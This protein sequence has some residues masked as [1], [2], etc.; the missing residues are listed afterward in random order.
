MTT[1]SPAAAP[2]EDLTAAYARAKADDPGAR[3]RDIADKLGVTEGRLVDARAGDGVERLAL[4]GPAFAP[5][6]DTIRAAGPMMT[7]TRNDAAVHE[8]TGEMGEVKHHGPMGQVTGAIDLRLFLRHWHAGFAVREETRSGLRHSIQ[9]FDATG[10]AILKV[11]AVEGTDLEHW[12]RIAADHAARRGESA[13]FQMP[14]PPIPDPADDE[15]D[16]P[17]L[18]RRW[19]GLEHSHDFPAMLRSVGAGRQQALRLVGEDL[20]RPVAADITARMLEMA[21]Q[22]RIPIMCFVGNRG[23]IQIYSGPVER[24]VPMGPWLNILDPGFNLHLRADRVAGSWVVV[25]PTAMRGRITS[26]E[27]FDADGGLICQFFGA[28][29]PGEGEQDGWRGLMTELTGGAA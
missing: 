24:I 20:A 16:Q 6:L 3:A 5:F 11:Y 17:E 26:L 1:A 27:L 19:E 15:I 23:C 28:R 14:E 8:T 25:K 13:G 18:R 2:V 21:A 12:S 7:L 10:V 4:Q 9:I 29:P 22:R